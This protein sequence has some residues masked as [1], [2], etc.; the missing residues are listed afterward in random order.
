MALIGDR[1][2]HAARSNGWLDLG[3]ASR[4]DGG[5]Y[6]HGREEI[7][8]F[9]GTVRGAVITIESV[10]VLVTSFAPAHA[11]PRRC[12]A[13]LAPTLRAVA[14]CFCAILCGGAQS[15]DGG[16]PIPISNG[17]HL[18]WTQLADSA[19]ALHAHTF[20][21]YV[22]GRVAEL[23]ALRCQ[24]IRSPFSYE[25]R[26]G[27][28]SM[29]AGRHV[30]VLT[31]VF[32]GIESSQSEP[33]V[34]IVSV[35]TQTARLT[36]V[37]T[38]QSSSTSSQVCTAATNR[39]CFDIKT[40]AS[41]LDRVSGLASAADGRL[42]VVEG[43]TRFRVIA[44]G[45][46][47]DEPALELHDAR[48]RI[49]GL[50]VDPRSSDSR[51]VFVAWT[52][53]TSAGGVV[54]NVTRYLALGNSLGEG[55]TIVSGLPFS[56]DS[57]APLAVDGEGLLYVA[58]PDKAVTNR[59]GAQEAPFGGAVLR[60]DRDGLV[61]NANGRTSPVLSYGYAQPSGLAID[62][63][64]G[65]VWLAGTSDPAQS[66]A[67]VGLLARE[68]Q[69]WPLRPVVVDTS[70]IVGV[71]VAERMGSAL[72]FAGKEDAGAAL[73]IANDRIFR[74]SSTREGRFVA[75]GELTLTQGAPLAVASISMGS[76]YVAVLT[77]QGTSI[78]RLDRRR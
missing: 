38:A 57:L 23:S 73:L 48:S 29:T 58:L 33:L 43:G 35:S 34:V 51:T 21:L 10:D 19:E 44:E 46:L 76:W 50:A 42:L 77:D 22:D 14:V 49:V 66:L 62:P 8:R 40:I 67:S 47:L 28:P 54:L 69:S 75:L 39:E 31:S 64:Y 27:L 26:G 60:V 65:R 12:L 56:D 72:A 5:S 32:N 45:R 63:T 71:R 18:A 17:Q 15:P 3:G 11:L 1:K 74:V 55:A 13:R 30:L 37:G 16:D 78:L 53:P 2:D 4:R 70:A 9:S 68:G 61:P 59:T 20:R 52:E 25:C 6:V 41:G 7:N 36:A 24:A